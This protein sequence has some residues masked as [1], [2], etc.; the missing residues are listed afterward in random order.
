MKKTIGMMMLAA[1]TVV[2]SACGGGN[3]LQQVADKAAKQLP[4]ALPAVGAVEGLQMGQEE[5]TVEVKTVMDEA[6]VKYVASDKADLSEVKKTVVYALLNGGNTVQALLQRIGQK[7]GTL[8]F[9][10]SKYPD[11]AFAIS[12][13]EIKEAMDGVG[14]LSKTDKGLAMMQA[15]AAIDQ[16]GVPLKLND[17][18]T[19]TKVSIDKDDK[20]LELEFTY[21]E[22]KGKLKAGADGEN[23]MKS[24][25]SGL[26]RTKRS[27]G[28][29]L[30]EGLVALGSAAADAGYGVKH[31]VKGSSTGTELEFDYNSY[32]MNNYVNGLQ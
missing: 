11:A 25:M 2:L 21:D 13:K 7:D 14:R 16:A 23:K 9:V 28:M 8:K 15:L 19:L 24:Y 27:G 6:F 18:A 29:E 5:N 4:G 31:D 32:L 17:E 30:N 22:G 3:D 1:L 20:Q 12:G 26:Y 10:D